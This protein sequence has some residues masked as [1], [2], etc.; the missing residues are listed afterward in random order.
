MVVALAPS[1]QF[2]GL[3]N[4][5]N[6]LALGKLYAYAAGTTTPLATYT[7]STGVTPNPNPVILDSAGR[8][9]VWLTQAIGY[10]LVLKDASESATFWTQDNI[11]ANPQATP[12]AINSYSA[13]VSQRNETMDPG[14]PGSEVLAQT[15]ADELKQQRKMFTE[16]KRTAT[17]DQSTRI[18]RVL[19]VLIPGINAQGGAL[20]DGVTAT[21]TGT[22]LVPDDYAGG[23]ITLGY[24]SRVNSST[25]SVIVFHTIFRFRNN[26]AFTTLLN[27]VN[28]QFTPTDTNS[29]EALRVVAA[30]D[31][32]IGDFLRFDVTRDGASDANG[33]TFVV[34]CFFVDYTTYAGA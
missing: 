18:K 34:D 12:T 32:A 27:N 2:V 30:S 15:I 7:D 16:M 25:G 8:A 1:P 3:D 28:S 13:T 4:N 22:W 5:G 14:E 20:P 6:P 23:N 17:W 9:S 31:I 21:V 19:F 10:K 24:T 26:T 33:N 29:H 11:I